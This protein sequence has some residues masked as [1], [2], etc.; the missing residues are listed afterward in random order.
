VRSATLGQIENIAERFES[1]F[2]LEMFRR[3]NYCR[4][5]ELAVKQAYDAKR[6][7]IPIYLS[8]GSEF[9]AAALSMAAP[10][11]KIFGQHRC[12]SLYLSY[13]GR[14][15]ALRDELLGLPSGCSGG[16]SGSNAIQGLPDIPM[17]G[18]SGLMGEQV[19][20]AVGAALASGE[21]CLTICGDASIEEDYM[22][23]SLGFAATR[24]LPVLFICEDNDLSILTPVNARRTWS[25]VSM[26]QSLGI[27]AIDIADDPWVLA[28]HVRELGKQLPAFINLRTVRVLWHAGSGQDGSPEWDRYA[29]VVEQMKKLG[30]SEEIERIDRENQEKVN[31][32]WESR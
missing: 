12:H 24:R 5:F 9:N 8:V 11:F 16:M 18:H 20:I 14:P 6:F 1:S 21:P 31:A 19:P 22:Y 30:L 10:G 32:L 15:E 28:W 7:T 23:P 25:P 17:F 4:H 27:T 3:G 26:A 13:G 2:S 29:M